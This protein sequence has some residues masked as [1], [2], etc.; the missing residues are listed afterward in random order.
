MGSYRSKEDE[1][2]KISTSKAGKQFGFVRF[3]KVSDVDRLV[4]NLCTV[5]VGRHK[6]Q[7]NIPRF[8]R[9]PLK[10]HISLH[11]IDGVKRGNSGD[12][13]NSNRVKGVA[14]SYAHVVKGSQNSKMDLDS[15]PVMVLDDSCLNEKDYSLCLMGKVKDFA[16]LANLKV[17]IQLAFSDFNTDGRVTWVEIEGIPLKMWSKNM[18]NRVA[19]KWGVLL[20][21]DD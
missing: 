3:I 10:R 1:V 16:T 8:Q 7:A 17:V 2:L 5:W 11:N 20:D 6:L 18:F 9:K 19:S 12:T 21:V 15:S 13:Y 4:N 14:N